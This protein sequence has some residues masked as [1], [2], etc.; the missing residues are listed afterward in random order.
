ML[1]RIKQDDFLKDNLSWLCIEPML[2]SIRGK[3]LDEKSAMYNQLNEGQRALYLFYAFYNHV[4]SIEE[5]Y[6]FATYFMGELKA[7]NGLKSGVRFYK[8]YEFA[9]ILEQLEK[10][11]EKR[12]KDFE[13]RWNEA[14]PTDLE[15]D[16]ELSLLIRPIYKAY[17]QSV[18]EYKERMNTYIR[19][20]KEDFLEIED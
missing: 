8:D 18:E 3:N 14:S 15:K 2:I 20:N 5:F 9:D 16:I 4:H 10:I 11:I 12:N 6:W 19:N 17:Q 13:G 1:T 7:W